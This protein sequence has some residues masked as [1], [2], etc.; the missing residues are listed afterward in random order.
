MTSHEGTSVTRPPLFDGTN[1]AFWKVRMRTYLMAL[2]ADV[3]DVVESGYIKPVVL[4]S[5]DDKLEFSVVSL[6]TTEAFKPLATNLYMDFYIKHTELYNHMRNNK[7]IHFNSQNKH[8][9]TVIIRQSIAFNSNSF[10]QR[11]T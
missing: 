11:K 10:T 9:V 5:K 8:I 7:E 3:W 4:A 6:F 2:R 1:F